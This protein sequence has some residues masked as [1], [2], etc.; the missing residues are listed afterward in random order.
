VE[1]NR[2]SKEIAKLDLVGG[3][4]ALDFVNTLA[5]LRRTGPL[6]DDEWLHSYD[7]LLTFG[8]RTGTLDSSA[9]AKLTRT[10]RRRPAEARAALAAA[11]ELR[12]VIEHAFRPLADGGRPA[13]NVLHALHRADATALRHAELVP[14][15]S[16][17]RWS[18]DGLTELEAP[19]WPLAHGAVELLTGGPLERLKG[20]GR[21]RWLFLDESKNRSRRWCSMEECGTD[22]KKER[23]IQR[24]RER[25]R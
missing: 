9:A 16:G 21:C 25:R 13:D 7:D 5:G 8:V 3:H 4:P 12:K 6:P 22:E 18:W 2:L 20:C 1:T 17:Y 15:G 14:E 19:L 24:R 23:Y 11:L 10:A